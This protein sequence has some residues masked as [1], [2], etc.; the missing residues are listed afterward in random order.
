M[1]N[2]IE[3]KN[4]ARIWSTKYL[5]YDEVNRTHVQETF[6][7][8][9]VAG[10]Q[11]RIDEVSM[12][13]CTEKEGCTASVMVTAE[14]NGVDTELGEWSETSVLPKYVQKAITPAFLA[15][16]GKEII[17]RFHLKTSN[18]A[19]K[20]YM[21]VCACKYSVVEPE[22]PVDEPDG[23]TGGDAQVLI[24]IECSSDIDVEKQVEELSAKF[25]AGKVKTYNLR[26]PPE[27]G[28]V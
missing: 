22:P 14:V 23:N 7:I 21:S 25:G 3:L 11:L 19:F 16:E 12:N 24:F 18:A 28:N 8:P 20:A 13:I 2:E 27:V 6:R 15:E 17:L 1:E 10:K 9:A 5:D 4:D 26:K